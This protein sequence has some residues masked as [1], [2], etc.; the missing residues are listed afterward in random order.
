MPVN[1]VA[2]YYG[3]SHLYTFLRGFSGMFSVSLLL[4]SF[5]ALQ[6]HSHNSFP[7]SDGA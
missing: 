3:R 5:L 7:D 2:K 6:F 1:E 4:F